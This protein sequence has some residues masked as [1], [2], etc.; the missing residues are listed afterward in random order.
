MIK[1]IGFKPPMSAITV[2]AYTITLIL[3]FQDNIIRFEH[4]YSVNLIKL[5]GKFWFEAGNCEE[6]E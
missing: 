2:Q 4:G 6:G 5:C 3:L 1:C